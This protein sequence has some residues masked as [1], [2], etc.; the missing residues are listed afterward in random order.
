[1]A[2][3]ILKHNDS[4]IEN[5]I[6]KYL[7]EAKERLDSD[8]IG[9]REAIK[10]ISDEKVKEFILYADMKFGK[11]EAELLKALYASSMCQAFCYGYGLGKAEETANRKILL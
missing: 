3:P 4:E 6:R 8:F 7:S 10:E 5:I 9:S 2:Q 11:K 1:M